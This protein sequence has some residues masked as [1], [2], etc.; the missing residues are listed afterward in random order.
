MADW[1]VAV[2]SFRLRRCV[3]V[4]VVALDG[5]AVVGERRRQR[6]VVAG[7]ERA[8]VGVVGREIGWGPGRRSGTTEFTG[9]GWLGR[10]ST[11][12]RQRSSRRQPQTPL[13]RSPSRCLIA[14]A[15]IPRCPSRRADRRNQHRRT[16]LPP[17]PRWHP[18]IEPRSASAPPSAPSGPRHRP[19]PPPCSM[20][21]PDSPRQDL[22]RAANAVAPAPAQAST[23]PASEVANRPLPRQG[24][25]DAA[26]FPR[27]RCGSPPSGPRA[28]RHRRRR[29]RRHPSTGGC[30]GEHPQPPSPRRHRNRHPR[31]R[32]PLPAR[33]GGRFRRCAGGRVW[34][35]SVSS[36][37]V[38][39]SV[40][41]SPA[42]VSGGPFWSC[43]PLPRRWPRPDTGGCLVTAVRA[44]RRSV[45]FPK[46]STRRT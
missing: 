44:L 31:P 2:G 28:H 24:I 33:V 17:P 9:T 15:P 26:R 42:V 37:S 23:A 46:P 6:L 13:R 20:R 34:C 32:C 16:G 43:T 35:L 25:P 29:R 36:S 45:R 3:R 18:S 38:R 19:T 8:V 11:T 12:C 10:R 40:G 5:F 22:R 7:V 14:F 39:G 4:G 1:A 41:G 21:S 27:N 30:R